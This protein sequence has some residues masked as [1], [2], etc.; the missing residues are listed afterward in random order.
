MSL[1]VLHALNY[2]DHTERLLEIIKAKT[3]DPKLIE[4]AI[5]IMRGAG[6]FEFAKQKMHQLINEA[7]DEAS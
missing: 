5:S 2:S 6:S 1:M 7:W 4:E 3:E